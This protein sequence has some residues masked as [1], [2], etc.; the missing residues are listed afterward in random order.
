MVT[1]STQWNFA[2]LGDGAR[3]ASAV[4][5][6][7]STFALRRAARTRAAPRR[8]PENTMSPENYSELIASLSD[9]TGT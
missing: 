5:P 6:E 3:A 1:N 8:G 7:G 4:H 2:A 9:P